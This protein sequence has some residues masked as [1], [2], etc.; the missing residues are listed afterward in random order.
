MDA[1][2]VPNQSFF[3]DPV[4]HLPETLSR[5]LLCHN[6]KFINYSAIIAMTLVMVNRP[7]KIHQFT[8]P[9]Q[10]NLVR[11]AKMINA[12]ALLGGP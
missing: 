1:F 5:P 9:T 3:S 10:T 4:V 12:D 11:L 7:R 2:M 8:G 6:L